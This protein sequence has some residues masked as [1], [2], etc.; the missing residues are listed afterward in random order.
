MRDRR[1]VARRAPTLVAE[2]RGGLANKGW[3]SLAGDL[4]SLA[5]GGILPLAFAPYELAPLAVLSL[6]VLFYLWDEVS[7]RRA[8]WRGWLYGVG[9]LGTGVSWVQIS[10]H[11][12]G[13]PVLAFSVTVTVAFIAFVALYPG[14][15]GALANRWFRVSATARFLLV[16]PALWMLMEWFKGWVL[17]G[18]PWLN[19]GYSQVDTPLAGLAPVFGVYGV[20]FAAALSAGLLCALLRSPSRLG[21]AVF[22]SLLWLAAFGLGRVTWTA[23]QA[24]ESLS[25]ALIQGNVAQTMKWLPAERQATIDRY[26]GLTAS[27]WGKADLVVWPETAIPEF[28]TET[29]AYVR[30]LTEQ[31]RQTGTEILLGVPYREAGGERYY[32]AVATIGRHAGVYRKR[33]LVPFGE[34]LPFPALLGKLLYFLDIPMSSFSAGSRGQ[35]PL[36]AAGV[37]V[38]VSICYEDAFGEEVIEQL[39]VARLL[40]NVS[41]DAWFGDSIA[42]HQHLQMARMRALEGGRFL[43]RATNNGISAVVDHRGKVIAQAPQFRPYTLKARIRARSGATPYVM[44]GNGPMVALAAGL[45]A[46]ALVFFRVRA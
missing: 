15:I 6:A 8:F 42:P 34:Y 29:A 14:L 19:V 39:P 1:A 32:N 9:M 3:L 27:S 18:F 11:Q 25:V 23:A 40:V 17:T 37:P 33:H 26:L 12:F 5:A 41:N 13:M 38:G 22:L 2:W 7:P 4:A 28:Y 43:L 44:F 30:V 16:L 24:T 21:Y 45:L 36:V 10:I 35:A 31:V 20:S 46:V